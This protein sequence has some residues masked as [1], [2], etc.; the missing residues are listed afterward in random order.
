VLDEAQRNLEPLTHDLPLIVDLDVPVQQVAPRAYIDHLIA[1]HPLANSAGNFVIYTNNPLFPKFPAYQSLANDK[2]RPFDML[3]N[4]SAMNVEFTRK[5]ESEIGSKLSADCEPRQSVFRDKPNKPE[6]TVWYFPGA[7]RHPETLRVE[8]STETIK[9]VEPSFR[10]RRDFDEATFHLHFSA[11]TG[12][13]PLNLDYDLEN[14]Q[15]KF[16]SREGEAVAYDIKK[17]KCDN[18]LKNGPCFFGQTRRHTTWPG[19]R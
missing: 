3:A 12:I 1:A 18:D 4:G 15:I 5:G 8:C 17:T 9:Y 10:S 13:Q 6:K 19:Y 2:E 11:S 7:S 14:F 16:K